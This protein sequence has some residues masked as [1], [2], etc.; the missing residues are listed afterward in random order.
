M[1]INKIVV[2][3]ILLFFYTAAFAASGI[4]YLPPAQSTQGKIIQ[5]TS[6]MQ[7]TAPPKLPATT[8]VH[9]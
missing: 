3:L 2:A 5:Q 8:A 9:K 7:Q 1:R 4:E 6:K